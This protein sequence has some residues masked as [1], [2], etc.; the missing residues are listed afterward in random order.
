MVRDTMLAVGSEPG[1]NASVGS[2][3]EPAVNAP[4]TSKVLS[5]MAVASSR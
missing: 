2:T 1:V 5:D 4:T 3:I